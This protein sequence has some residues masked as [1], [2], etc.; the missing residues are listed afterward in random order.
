MTDM[1]RAFKS[2]KK[3]IKKL[4]LV[5]TDASA[6]FLAE[7]ED[8]VRDY[9][10]AADVTDFSAVTARFGTPQRIAREFFAQTDIAAVRKKLD[11]RRGI[12]AA[13][14]AALLIWGAA[15]GALYVEARNEMNGTFI[16]DT[17]V[18][19]VTLP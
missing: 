7:L 2:Y 6:R 8:N 12:L 16:E 10:E 1:E 19:E 11:I 4:L 15:V 13:A 18:S 14:L 3:Q 5:K 9:I 17:A